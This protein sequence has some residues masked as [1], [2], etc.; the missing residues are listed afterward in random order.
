MKSPEEKT[1]PSTAPST[2]PSPETHLV[3]EEGAAIQALRKI[4][5]AAIGGYLTPYLC[6]EIVTAALDPVEDHLVS[7]SFEDGIRAA[8][9]LFITDASEP[10]D[11]L[12]RLTREADRQRILSLMAPPAPQTNLGVPQDIST[13]PSMADV[14]VW[15][16]IVKL[17]ENGDPTDEIVDG[18]W[19]IS[20]DQ[21]GYW[22]EPEVM[23]AIGDQ[24]GD[25]H[26]YA[27][28]PSHW[29][30]LPARLFTATTEGSD[31]G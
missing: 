12:T 17:D 24:M 31:N 6:A 28:K 27:D 25:D 26:T 30:P 20:E 23:N 3:V 4:E 8:S 5:A 1:A 15:W 9:N 2:T 13:A 22:I 10:V 11:D 18:C 19:I 14:L 7:A 21:G 16:P 29:M